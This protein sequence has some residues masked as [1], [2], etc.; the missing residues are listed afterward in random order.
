MS[1]PP[2][3]ELLQQQY[4]TYQQTIAEI[5]SKLNELKNDEDEHKIVLETLKK[6][7]VERR[8]FRMVGGAL[9][10]KDVET[11]IPVLDI[12]LENITK[13]INQLSQELKE[14]IEEFEKWKVEKHIK[15]I[16]K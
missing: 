4:N 5:Q 8:C 16:R 11:T 2:N 7:P 13:T 12:K 15:I 14:I 6:T 10:E 3:T 9:I 1:Q